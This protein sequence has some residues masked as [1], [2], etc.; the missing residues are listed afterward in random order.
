METLFNWLWQGVAVAVLS[1]L[2]IALTPLSASQRYRLWW[3]TLGVVLALPIVSYTWSGIPSSGA[4][5]T[6]PG[7]SNPGGC[8]SC[9]L[10]L[11]LPASRS[12][13]AVAAASA[14]LLWLVASLTRTGAAAVALRRSRRRTRPFPAEREARLTHWQSVRSCGRKGSLVLSNDVRLAA[15]FGL[16]TPMIAV[17]PRL[18]DHLSDAELDRVA[19]HEWAHVQR[20][21]DLARLAQRLVH[22]IAGLHPAVW[23]IGRHIDLEREIACDDWTIN[24]AGSAKSYATALTKLASLARLQP[25]GTLLPAALT[26]SHLTTR[27]VRLL[28]ERRRSTSTYARASVLAGTA[29]ALLTASI[30]LAVFR[31]VVVAEEASSE[32]TAGVVAIGGERDQ[33][34]DAPR[35][36][37]PAEIHAAASRDSAAPPRRRPNASVKRETAS[38]DS[39]GDAGLSS[40]IAPE[41]PAG[42][43][44][45]QLAESSSEWLDVPGSVLPAAVEHVQQIPSTRSTDAEA[46]STPWG[47]AADAGV[48]VG[49]GSQK[50][51]VATAGFFTRMGRSIAGSFK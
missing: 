27:V 45:P 12:A 7:A 36:A 16:G 30:P 24:L 11:A 5:A 15:V 10:S 4:P 13:I 48:S 42:V 37:A 33:G 32:A 26:R 18:L 19:V 23:W 47:A 28:D 50:A 44:L 41:L 1:R 6:P 34:Q 20:R 17:S 51:A 31:L 29:A 38:V 43:V 8:E 49:R 39:P 21:D 46:G 14:W 9:V 35:P 22:G 25:A 2:I 3:M 40:L